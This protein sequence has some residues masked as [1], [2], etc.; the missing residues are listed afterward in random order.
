MTSQTV[1]HEGEAGG[2][3]AAIAAFD[4]AA[5]PLGPR[6]GWPQSLRSA[7]DTMLDAGFAMFVAWGPALTFLYNDAY[8][9][10]LGA[11]HPAA[12]GATFADAWPDVWADVS[13]LVDRVL[14]GESVSFDDMH[15]VMTR[16]GYDED[17]WW[18]FSYSP[19]RDE[20]GAI[21]GV[22]DVCVDVTAKVLND[23]ALAQERALLG[24]SEGRFRAL[25]DASADVIYRMSADWQEMRQLDGRGFLTDTDAPSVRW[26]EEYLPPDERPAVRAEIARAIRD[27]GPFD[28]EHRVL[29]ADGTI[30]WTRSRAIPILDD[31]GAIVEWFGAASDVTGEHESRAALARSREKLALATQAAQLGQFDF[32]PQ[33]GRLEWDD[34]CRALFG[35]PPGAPIT[36]ESAFLAGLHPDDLA[37]SDAAVA[38]V[39]DPAGDRTLD[40]EY[41]TIGIDDGVERHV[42]AQGHAIFDG[43]V[44]MRLIG[45]VQDV[46]ADRRGQAALRETEERLRLAA[47]AT[48]DAIWDWDLL[49]DRVEWNAALHSAYG[50]APR[51]VEPTGGWW[52]AQ[53]HP[54]DRARI[55]HSIH[56]VID[57]TGHDWTDEYRFRR[58]DGSYADVKDRGYVIRDRAGHAI[59]MIGA[60]LDVTDLKEAERGL[61]RQV[62]TAEG[63]RRRLWDMTNDLMA[64]AGVDGYLKAINPAWTR[65]LGW[66][67]AHLL[68]RPFAEFIDPADREETRNVIERLAAGET[69]TGFVEQLVTRDGD[70]RTIM[71]DAVPQGDIFYVVGRDLTEQRAAEDRLRQAQKMEAVGQ[72]TGGIAHDFNNM[73]TG[74]I[75][76]MDLLKRHLAEGRT[77]RVDRY[78]DAATTSAQRAAGLTQRLLAF[79]RRQSLD[80]QA[81]DVNATIVGMEDLLRRTL[82]ERIGLALELDA[83]AGIVLTDANQLESALLNLAIN[84]RD[85][86]A[87]GGTLTV[88]N[89]VVRL[90]ADY[91]RDLE[92][93]EPGDYVVLCVADTGTGM[94][95]DVIAKAFDP[96]FTTKPIGQ[97][98]GLGLSM[99]Y[100]F[101]RQTDG[102]VRIV[103]AP[104][105]GTTVNLYLRR[106]E[107]EAEAAAPDALPLR[108]AEGECV[109]VVEDDPAVRMLVTE[110][111][112]TLGYG[113]IAAHDGRQAARLLDA[114]PPIDLL[115]TDVGLPGMNGR[116]VADYARERLPGLKVLFVTGYAE[117]AAIRSGFLAEGMDLI[118]KPFAI[119]ALSAKIR[120][121]IEG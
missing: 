30:G 97:G 54:D 98:T 47:Q 101:M 82:G 28:L 79:S 108:P 25:V 109:M 100:G 81:V 64:T 74:V 77:D 18:Q 117:Q 118:T 60:M 89:A 107:G 61:T 13:P 114:R 73:L 121:M 104:G 66:D 67:E 96:F 43:D 31:G 51:R 68:A 90:D 84:A 65:L 78:V 75:G 1:S 48:N 106:H 36:Y 102:H 37:A 21:V 94:T 88:R 27:R 40:V 93:L 52:I 115:V 42:H 83:D 80:V 91:V 71:W 35:L 105:Q 116:Q 56:A 32:W 58:G 20:A 29:R 44:P 103:S 7:V 87:D 23:R 41:R 55:D 119:D 85:A 112:E 34:R 110:V 15:L 14:A 46:T 120:E 33:E 17:T 24:E 63:E 5:T 59:R 10:M 53:I 111:L 76:S 4:W 49:R 8:R 95:P 16:N 39:L 19:L 57:G 70:R 26:I 2:M 50:H 12:L 69:V 9:P 6:E 113:V 72:L 38:R 22:L 99:I 62:E 86:M 3:R 45:T 11:R 92:G